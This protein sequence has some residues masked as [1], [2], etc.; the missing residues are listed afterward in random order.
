M[1]ERAF[2]S[3][4]VIALVSAFPVLLVIKTLLGDKLGGDRLSPNLNH[5]PY[6]L[7]LINL[8]GLSFL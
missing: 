6:I 3:D 7:P 5:L 2:N 1:P 8:S 4:V